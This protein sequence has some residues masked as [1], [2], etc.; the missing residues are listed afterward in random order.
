MIERIAPNAIDWKVELRK[1]THAK[2][3]QGNR[4]IYK[5]YEKMSHLRKRGKVE[6]ARRNIY[7]MMSCEVW[8]AKGW[9]KKEDYIM[10]N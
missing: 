4:K 3:E 7:S 6:D 1:W 8:K 2:G 10:E 9:T 5:N